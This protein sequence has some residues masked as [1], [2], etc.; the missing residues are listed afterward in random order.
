[1][2]QPKGSE[3][4]DGPYT[5]QRLS[6][7]FELRDRHWLSAGGAMIGSRLAMSCST[8][9]PGILPGVRSRRRD[10]FAGGDPDA[11]GEEA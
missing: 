4:F 9:M 6:T 10:L 2:G 7:P 5:Y 11:R 8:A 3:V 1:L